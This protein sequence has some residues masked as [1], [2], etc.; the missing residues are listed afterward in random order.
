MIWKASSDLARYHAV[1]HTIY[2]RLQQGLK[3]ADWTEEKIKRE[4]EKTA[5]ALLRQGV[6]HESPIETGR[7]D[8]SSHTRFDIE[9]LNDSELLHLHSN[10]HSLYSKLSA[11]LV[12]TGWTIDQLI[13]EHDDVVAQMTGRGMEHESPME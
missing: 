8:K 5:A 6:K 9:G 12:G 11:G 4:H 2:G 10:L 7:P 13:T 1:L 3:Q